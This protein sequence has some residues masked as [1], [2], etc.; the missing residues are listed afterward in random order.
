MDLM[1]SNRAL[2]AAPLAK[3]TTAPADSLSF[4]VA[5]CALGKV[6]VA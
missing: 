6:L 2:R 5:N 4:A 1:I 3:P